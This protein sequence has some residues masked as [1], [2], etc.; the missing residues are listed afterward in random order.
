MNIF[1]S[2]DDA[3]SWYKFDANQGAVIPVAGI[4]EM[5]SHPLFADRLQED[6]YLR[7]EKLF[8]EFMAGLAG[9]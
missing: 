6:Y 9:G 2:E 1:R 5:F 4:V 8:A 3:R 7:Q